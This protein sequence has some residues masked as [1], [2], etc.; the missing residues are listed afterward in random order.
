MLIHVKGLASRFQD[1]ASVPSQAVL[2]TGK[3]HRRLITCLFG[4]HADSEAYGNKNKQKL[5]QVCIVSSPFGP[6][7]RFSF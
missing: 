5:V 1:H 7:D 2:K 6:N 4:S 3:K